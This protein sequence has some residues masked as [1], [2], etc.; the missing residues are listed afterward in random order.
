VKQ[1]VKKKNVFQ[2]RK[3]ENALITKNSEKKNSEREILKANVEN[4]E[5]RN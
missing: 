3:G 5:K 1:Q 2:E 4:R